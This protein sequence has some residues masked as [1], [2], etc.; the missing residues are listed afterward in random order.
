MDVIK[1]GWEHEYAFAKYDTISFSLLSCVPQCNILS[2]RDG[3][4]EVL[5]LE[6]KPWAVNE[7]TCNFNLGAQFKCTVVCVSNSDI[8]VRD[9]LIGS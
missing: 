3:G 5:R 4:L 2:W 6:L 7:E 9:L 8:H 1:S